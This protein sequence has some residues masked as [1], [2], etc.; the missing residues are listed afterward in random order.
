MKN[1]WLGYVAASIVSL[2][3]YGC[4]S[5][6]GE[7]QFMPEQVLTNALEEPQATLEYYGEATIKMYEKDEV[8]DTIQLKEWVNEQGHRKAE[9]SEGEDKS[10]ALNDG[11]KL[12]TYTPKTNT[13]FTIEDAELLSM[14]QMSPKE[15]AESLLKVIRDT[16][17]LTEGE[18]QEVAGRKTYHLIAKAKDKAN[19]LGDIEVWIDKENWMVLKMISTSGDIKTDYEYT[20]LE[21]NPKFTSETFTIELPS[22]VTIESMDDLQQATEVTL[23]EAVKSIGKSF[24]V[25]PEIE[26]L[27]IARIEQLE[28][29]GE[30][31]RTEINI[32]YEKDGFP[33]FFITVFPSDEKLEATF[34]DEEDITIRGQQA[35]YMEMNDFR[36]LTWQEEG[37]N[38]S[39]VFSDTELSL[40]RFQHL[41]E[42]M[43]EASKINE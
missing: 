7:N 5:T 8:I 37:L 6:A 43:V 25:L 22:D 11:K 14:N 34:A 33:Y 32:E 20:K 41:A 23:E 29:K 35:L 26:G 2:S 18:D 13:A 28:L 4:G 10:I 21:F 12:T 15:Q 19:L 39:V 30:L 38:Y 9:T 24:F 31:N 42:S 1:K 16:H 17:D 27:T 3:L 40:E 36:S